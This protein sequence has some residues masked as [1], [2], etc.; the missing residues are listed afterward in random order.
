MKKEYIIEL[1][2]KYFS[3]KTS[4]EEEKKL[5]QYFSS[6]RI[7]QELKKYEPL[8]QY[9][10]KSGKEQLSNRPLFPDTTQ[11]EKR[12]IRTRIIS[13]AFAAASV[14]LIAGLFLLLQTEKKNIQ[15]TVSDP[16][17]AY[18]QTKE[19][20]LY[21]SKTLNKGLEKTKTLETFNTGV[22]NLKKVDKIEKSL[23]SVDQLSKFRRI[24]IFVKTSY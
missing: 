12:I 19:A 5:K 21:V 11:K 7:S 13:I 17:V 14:L 20:L 22:E 3:G 8:F 2:E 24:S 6:A 1:I 18:N 10:E 4:L 9:Y 23:E 15:S 16:V